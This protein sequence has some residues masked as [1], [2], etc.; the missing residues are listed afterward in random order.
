MNVN[1]KNWN[2]AF[3]RAVACLVALGLFIYGIHQLQ[4]YLLSP[5]F[6]AASAVSC[7][8]E[9]PITDEAY[10]A[11]VES[12]N[13]AMRSNALLLEREKLVATINSLRNPNAIIASLSQPFQALRS[14]AIEFTEVL[15]AQRNT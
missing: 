7:Q 13:Q 10:A 9:M 12:D 3:N 4:A 11:L 1:E 15:I 5:K 14:A 6:I 2:R 8:G